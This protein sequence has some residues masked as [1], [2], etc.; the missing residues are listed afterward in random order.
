MLILG[1]GTV[2]AFLAGEGDLSESAP[3]PPTVLY[4]DPMGVRARLPADSFGGSAGV[5]TPHELRTPVDEATCTYEARFESPFD[6][7]L[8]GKLPGLLGVVPGS[9]P[10]L[11]TGGKPDPENLGWSGRL[12]WL[13]PDSGSWELPDGTRRRARSP[14]E[15]I[16]YMYHPGQ[17]DQ[18]GDNVWTGF[19]PPVGEWF[20]VQ[21]RHVMNTPGERNGVLQ[22]SLDGKLLVD[23]H[24]YVYRTRADL[25]I[26]HF[27]LAAFPGGNT[28]AYEAPTDRFIDFR[29]IVVT[30]PRQRGDSTA[31]R[32]ARASGTAR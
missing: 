24:H 17:D 25:H 31:A 10:T 23:R 8:G 14:A 13:T 4:E 21:T 12:M 28:T 1:V 27:L 30:T 32:P 22:I 6:W 7:V 18:F 15:I 26:T 16:G 11:P 19:T 5:N 3:A 2:A 29:N 20:T 9:S